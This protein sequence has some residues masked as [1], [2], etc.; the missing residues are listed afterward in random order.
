MPGETWYKRKQDLETYDWL[1]SLHIC[2]M[3]TV[4]VASSLREAVN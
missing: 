4:P 3:L 1:L 2:K